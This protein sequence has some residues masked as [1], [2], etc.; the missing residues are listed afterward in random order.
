[1]HEPIKRAVMEERCPVAAHRTVIAVW[2]DLFHADR[3]AQS[4]FTCGSYNA[5]DRFAIPRC[6]DH[7]IVFGATQETHCF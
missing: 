2:M 4:I 1:M 7:L 6:L 5:S 3:G